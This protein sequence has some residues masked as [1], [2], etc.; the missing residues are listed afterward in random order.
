M[1]E[2]MESG[3]L[4]TVTGR[5]RRFRVVHGDDSTHIL[6]QSVNFPIQ[7]TANDYL[8]T[9]LIEMTDGLAGFGARTLLSVH[10]SMLFN[11]PK[12]RL[13]DCIKYIQ[14]IMEKP[15]FDGYPSI[16]VEMKVGDNWGQMISYNV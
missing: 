11:I 16:E 15:R 1:R 2:A 4:V 10:D 14:T 6:R 9:S 3:E 7:A 13:T 8:L 12:S 5:K